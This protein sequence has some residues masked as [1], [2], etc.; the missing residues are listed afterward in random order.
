M[1]RK[2]TQMSVGIDAGA[3]LLLGSGACHGF[4][5]G[6]CLFVQDAAEGLRIGLNG[7]L[8]K[9]GD[10]T[11]TLSIAVAPFDIDD[12]TSVVD[13]QGGG[14]SIVHTFSKTGGIAEVATGA[15]FVTPAAQGYLAVSVD[16][17][18]EWAST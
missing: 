5:D 18:W 17:M 16:Q 1:G 7:D 15:A 14:P 9:S 4:P 8:Y 2:M 3:G 13:A 12:K 6:L 10:W 11:T